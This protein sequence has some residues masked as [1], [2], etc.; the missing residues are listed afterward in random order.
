L[1][2]EAPGVSDIEDELLVCATEAWGILPYASESDDTAAVARTV[3]D[4]V[5]RGRVTVHRIEQVTEPDG[6]TSSTYGPPLPRA[7]LPALLAATDTWDDP[8]HHTW[9][10]ELTLSRTNVRPGTHGGDRTT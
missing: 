2:W 5:D 9:A 1:V 6:T 3:L 8:E 7:D 4:L 10:G